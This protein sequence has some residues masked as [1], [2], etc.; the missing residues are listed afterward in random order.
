MTGKN[1]RA[2]AAKTGAQAG[3]E[4][5]MI[6]PNV[7][8]DVEP[9]MEPDMDQDQRARSFSDIRDFFHDGDYNGRRAVDNLMEELSGEYEEWKQEQ[10]AEQWDRDG[11]D[12]MRDFVE[13]NDLF[14]R[15]EAIDTA[16]DEV[17]D[18]N[19]DLPPES[20]DF[21]DLLRARLDELQEQF[22]LEEFEAQGLS[23]IHI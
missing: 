4:F 11:V 16:R 2:E 14:D 8:T 20:K 17:I 23:L 3:M 1:L 6:V 12:Y 19:P 5:E 21:Q 7:E 10:T 9:E 18:A 13:V 22:V 15:E